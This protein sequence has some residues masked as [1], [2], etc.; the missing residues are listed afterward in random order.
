M[1][2]YQAN[3]E[4]AAFGTC[5]EAEQQS[6]RGVVAKLMVQGGTLNIG[7]VVVCGSSF[8]RIKAIYDTLNR[9]KK[10]KT[11][12][13]STPVNVTGF[14]VAPAAGDK[15][16]VVDD[17]AKARE[18]AE[19]RRYK[20]TVE[21][22]GGRSTKTSLVD[23]QSRLESGDLS[24]GTSELV[25]L[26][27]IIRA[28]VRGSIEAIQKELGKIS[29]PE[30]QIK[31]LQ[32]LPGGISAADVRLAEASDAVIVG[33]NV[34]ADES[35]RSLA[36]ELKVEIRRY[37]VIYKITDDLKAT[38]EGRLKPE[39]QVVEVGMAMVLRVFNISKSGNIAG[40]RV[41]RGSIER[42]CRMRI[43]RD[44][45]VIGDYQIESLKREKDDAKEV[46][47]GMECGIKLAGFNDIKEGDTLEAYKIQEIARTL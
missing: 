39:E 20:G 17:I 2:N 24:G 6:D 29:H 43:V 16:F 12:E 37:E 26:N 1:H 32:A 36:E 11:A 35:A 3:P 31:V 47:R 34:I 13:P 18:L 14:D 25:T 46:Q 27:L 45:R 15:F 5:L 8:G 41:M 10:K 21:R 30:V 28:D 44:S 38:L 40:C 4:R 23:F 22:V 42:D 33:F 7:D 9:N 19:D